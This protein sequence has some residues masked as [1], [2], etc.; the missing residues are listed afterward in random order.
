MEE[1]DEIK[2][3]KNLRKAGLCLIAGMLLLA[4]SFWLPE[5]WQNYLIRQEQVDFISGYIE[6]PEE[7][8]PEESVSESE[9]EDP[10]GNSPMYR[11]IDFAGLQQINPE[12]VGWIYVPGTQIDYPICLGSDN[13]YYLTHSFRRSQNALGAIFAPAESSDDLGDA[14]TILYG[15]N[16]R[17]GKMFGELSNYESSE[18]RDRYPYVYIYTPDQSYT[19]T[20]YAAYR[21]RY[22]SAV[23]TIGYETGTEVFREWINDTVEHAAYD[24]GIAP[25]GQEQIFTLSTCV[26]SG[27]AKDRYVVQCVVTDHI[28]LEEVEE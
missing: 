7:N 11:N 1:P 3:V 20:V 18:F 23:Y 14:H 4:G 5:L 25:T 13:N 12:I 28:T 8:A 15:H 19:C 16:M 2:E 17:S 9:T 21:T 27:S 22:D 24:C 10:K 26:D 6:E